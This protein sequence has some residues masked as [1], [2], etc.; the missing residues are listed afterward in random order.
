MAR[1]GLRWDLKRFD[2][3]SLVGLQLASEEYNKAGS[4]A[5]TKGLDYDD[6]GIGG[7]DGASDGNG[8]SP[9]T[10]LNRRSA[11]MGEK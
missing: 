3:S 2:Q 8:R 1:T 5:A 9:V 10:L 6:K 4:E 11:K 7:V